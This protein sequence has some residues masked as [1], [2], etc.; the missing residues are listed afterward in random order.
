M[1]NQS[2]VLRKRANAHFRGRI[3]R[4]GRDSLPRRGPIGCQC[5]PIARLAPEM[6]R[7]VRFAQMAIK[8]SGLACLPQRLMGQRLK[9]QGGGAI[10]GAQQGQH[11]LRIALGQFHPGKQFGRGLVRLRPP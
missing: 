5:P 1:V 9:L 6:P 4:Q 8:I 10:V 2:F 3:G 7:S 11:R